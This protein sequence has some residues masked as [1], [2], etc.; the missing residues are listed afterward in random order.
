LP[1]IPSPFDGPI[2]G[3]IGKHFY[4]SSSPESVLFWM[5]QYK[6]KYYDNA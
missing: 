2:S 5:Q 4:A 6:K 1:Y 3:S